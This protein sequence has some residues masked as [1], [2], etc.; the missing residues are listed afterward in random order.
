MEGKMEDL[1][2]YSA[3][4]MSVLAPQLLLSCNS[5]KPQELLERSDFFV[6]QDYVS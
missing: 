4:Y 6:D 3:V 2:D 1:Y 5:T